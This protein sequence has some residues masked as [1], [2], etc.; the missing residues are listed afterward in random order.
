[1]SGKAIR[2]IVVA[3]LL[4]LV[5]TIHSPAFAVPSPDHVATPAMIM[6]EEHG[7]TAS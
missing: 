1:M 5:M 7:T 6:A 3:V 4:A 2:S